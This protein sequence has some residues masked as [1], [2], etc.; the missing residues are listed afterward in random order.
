MRAISCL[1]SLQHFILSLASISAL[2]TAYAV[3]LQSDCMTLDRR[4][5]IHIVNGKVAELGK[6]ISPSSHDK[7]TVHRLKK[8]DGKVDPGYVIKVYKGLDRVVKPTEVKGLKAA[9]QYIDS[10]ENGNA[11]VMKEVKG[12]SLARIVGKLPH[13]QRKVVVNGW[14]PKVAAEAARIASSKGVLHRDINMDNVIIHH[15]RVHLVDWENFYDKKSDQFTT[16]PKKILKDLDVVWDSSGTPQGHGHGTSSGSGSASPG[17][18]G[19]SRSASPGASGRNR[20]ASPGASSRSRLPSSSASSRSRLAS[21]AASSRSRSPSSGASSR[22]R[23]LSSIASSRSR[24]PS[25]GVSSGA[26]S[27]G[28]SP[29]SGASSRSR[30]ASFS[31]LSSI[32]SASSGAS[33]R[34]QSARTGASSKSQ[35]ASPRTSKSGSHKRRSPRRREVF[36]D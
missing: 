33:S 21:S 2:A 6:Q 31:T 3:P 8:W 28:R 4:A 9:G 22:S 14:K 13:D 20:S 32:R 12:K 26:P 23:S 29:S 17:A 15:N 24:S 10:E 19:R 18:S 27:R 30:S 35:S 16:D 34:S 36:Y 7:S 25:S 11:V 1:F 5:D